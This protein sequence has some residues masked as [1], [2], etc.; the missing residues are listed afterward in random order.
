MS[1]RVLL[2]SPWVPWPPHDGATI[3]I[4]NTLRY[5]AERHR[6]TLAAPFRSGN[7]PGDVAALR[8]LCED[9]VT[10]ELPGSAGAVASRAVA[11]AV[12]G[13]ALIQGI[14]YSPA[15]AERVRE[16]TARGAYDIVQVEF[17]WFTSYL[18]A[19]APRSRPRTVL[20][21]HNVESLRFARELRSAT[22]VTR[23]LVFGWDGLLRGGWEARAVTAV[24]AVTVVSEAERRWVERAAPSTRVTVV[25]NGVDTDHFRPLASEG[26]PRL[27]YTGSMDYPPNAD[28][29]LWF[30]REVWPA[31]RRR[32]PDL[33]LDIVGRRPDARVRRLDGQQGVRVAGEVSDVRPYLAQAR[34][35][36]VPLRAG[37]GTR[38]K[39]LEAM[40]MARPVVSTTLGAEG[41]EV[42]NGTHLLLADTP[43]GFVHAVEHVLT[44]PDLSRRLGEAGRERAVARY[45]WQRCLGPLDVLY[46][47]LL[48]ADASRAPRTVSSA[49]AQ[50][51][52][53][54]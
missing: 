15:L 14:H 20:S 52:A 23:R 27:V 7:E 51:A 49:R 32:A 50:G 31:L 54:S 17:S 3:R 22:T 40:A 11:A 30:C 19:L 38:L 33:G 18:D 45:D 46:E 41:L 2:L 37:A 44:S 5:L 10:G 25:P 39:I 47:R 12:R 6:V 35:V 29:V 36:V 48:R 28:A 53:G 13:R 1:L 8:H 16:V 34:A 42:V 9:I 4:F 21:M 24:D 26:P 43:A